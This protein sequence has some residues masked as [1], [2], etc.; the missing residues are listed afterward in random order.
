MDKVHNDLNLL[1][2]KNCQKIA[3]NRDGWNQRNSPLQ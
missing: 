3:A 2:I 1:G